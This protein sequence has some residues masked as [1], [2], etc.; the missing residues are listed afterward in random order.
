[1]PTRE[2]GAEYSIAAVSKLTGI[3]CHSLRVWERR[4]KFPVP[5]RSPSGH[6]RYSAEQV[7]HLEQIAQRHRQGAA[8]SELIALARAGG[9]E[10][11]TQSAIEATPFGQ[12]LDALLGGDFD[13]AGTIYDRQ[14][15]GLSIP[16]RIRQVIHPALV[17]VGERWFRGECQIFQEHAATDFLHRKIGLL[18]EEA[19][20]RNPEPSRSALVAT[21]EGDR[22]GGGVLMVTL[23]LEAAGW[24]AKPLGVDLPVSEIQA[25]VDR[26]R[27]DAVC[28]SFVLSRNV[29]KRFDELSAIRGAPV[30]VGGRSLLNYRTL[31]RRHGLI[32]LT[33]SG[34]QAV[35]RMIEGSGNRRLASKVNV[36]RL[37]AET[38]TATAPSRGIE[39]S[40][41]ESRL[42]PHPD[43]SP[44]RSS[45]CGGA[46]RGRRVQF[47]S[48]PLRPG[49]A[50]LAGACGLLIGAALAG[51]AGADLA[52]TWG[53]G[54]HLAGTGKHFDG[55]GAQAAGA[56]AGAGAHF[57]GTGGHFEG[58]AG[59]WPLA[60]P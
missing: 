50:A 51:T 52:G 21:V 2:N 9:L 13:A 19:R 42:S 18:I 58:T 34:E 53:D 39:G 54:A 31:A 43:R 32:P 25:A 36:R 7:H 29:N 30:F 10:G 1:M 56:G 37:A 41:R 28:L 24:R 46:G 57:D 4:F 44:D 45:G 17:E 20:A 35:R 3:G 8:L 49:G 11:A 40:P 14:I 12:L 48:A 15:A 47:R 33:G 22:H 6:R 27:P 26:W 16:E 55:A 59:H 5:Q 60:W 38:P 23:L